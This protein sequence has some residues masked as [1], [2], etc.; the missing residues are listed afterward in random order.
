MIELSRRRLTS[1]PLSRPAPIAKPIAMTT[2][3]P[4]R[5]LSPSGSWVTMTT[6]SETPPATDRSMPPCWTTSIWPRPA[7]ASTAA[8]GTMPTIALCEMLDGAIAAPSPNTAIVAIAIARK[9]RATRHRAWSGRVVSPVVAWF[10]MAPTIRPASRNRTV[11][12][13]TVHR[14]P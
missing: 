13:D 14:R 9:P 10:A 5:A 4:S 12:S 11:L 8:N 7:I 1:T 2:A 3:A 6:A